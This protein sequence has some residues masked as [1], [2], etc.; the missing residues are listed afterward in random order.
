MLFAKSILAVMASLFCSLAYGLMPVTD[1]ELSA[2]AE[3]RSLT[4]DNTGH[5]LKLAE[6][7]EK[8]EVTE[9]SSADTADDEKLIGQVNS[10]FQQGELQKARELLDQ[11]RLNARMSLGALFV[12]GMMYMQQMDYVSAASEFRAMLAR[13]SRLPWPR[14]ELALALYWSQSYGEARYHLELALVSDL[15]ENVRA[16]VQQYLTAVRPYLPSYSFSMD[17]MSD[18]NPKQTSSS[19]SVLIGGLPYLFNVAA[20]DKPV[21]G[22][23]MSLSGFFPLPKNPGWFMRTSASLTDFPNKDNDQLYLQ[24]TAG[25]YIYFPAHTL[26]LEFGAQDFVYQQRNLYSGVVLRAS[27][28]LRQNDHSVWQFVVEGRE[29]T[30]SL[31]NYLNGWQYVASTENQYALSTNS[32]LKTGLT[33]SE[34]EAHDAYNTYTSP[35]VYLSY[36][37]EWAGLVSNLRLQQSETNY[38][39]ADTLFGI[40]RHDS[41]QKVDLD[42]I[43]RNL[44]LHGLY[45]HLTVCAIRH[46][47]DVSLYDFSRR[48]IRV[49][50]SKEF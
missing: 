3:S 23:A 47:S 7:S 11:L 46:Q 40:V 30:Y 15:P 12:S 1:A 50:V 9:S 17:M 27:D 38:Q 18:S 34:T 32:R 35:S 29:Q 10:L 22:M 36:T 20:P 16:T 4:I 33:F 37:R 5:E 2:A 26:T 13:D 19:N 28:F 41:E 49:G 31:F 39:G 42:L 45:P 21:L 43:S 44:N 48:Y 8:K 25:K 6:N 24:G 14:L